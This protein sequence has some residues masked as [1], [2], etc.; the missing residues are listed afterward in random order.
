MQPKITPPSL[1]PDPEAVGWRRNPLPPGIMSV[2]ATTGN[3]PNVQQRGKISVPHSL[4]MTLS[5]WVRAQGR[6]QMKALSP[7]IPS[8]TACCTFNPTTLCRARGA[9]LALGTR[10]G[11]SPVRA[12]PLH[13]LAAQLQRDKTN[14]CCSGCSRDGPCGPGP[15]D[16]PPLPEAA[17]AQ[18]AEEEWNASSW[19]RLVK[20][21]K[22]D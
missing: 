7:S 2:P 21:N 3:Y 1:L 4:K 22:R 19:R 15:E 16:R 18:M 11:D 13:S 17:Q 8:A 12:L 5:F 9:W 14:G 10:A 6:T 20:R